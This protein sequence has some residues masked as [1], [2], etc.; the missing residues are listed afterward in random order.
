VESLAQFGGHFV[1]LVAL[2]DCDGTV[3]CVQDDSAML[4]TGGVGLEL[5]AEVSAELIVEIVA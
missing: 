5:I 3:R 2:V 4:A 1:E